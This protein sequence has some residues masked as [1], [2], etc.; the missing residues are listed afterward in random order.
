MG[1]LG[2]RTDDPLAGRRHPSAMRWVR[3]ELSSSFRSLLPGRQATCPHHDCRHQFTA[4]VGQRAQWKCVLVQRSCRTDGRRHVHLDRPTAGEEVQASDRNA[5]TA[6]PALCEEIP[7]GLETRVLRRAGI[8][9]WEQ[10]YS[11]ASVTCARRRIEADRTDA[12]VS[13]GA[14]P[15]APV[16]GRLRRDGRP[17]QP[18]GSLLSEGFRGN[19]QPS[20]RNYG[21]LLRDQPAC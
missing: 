19:G 1:L 13:S 12:H 4:F 17:R 15:A 21:L 14:R 10:L 11:P 5:L 20:F 6:P 16:A 18:L 2:L 7:H 8:L 3:Q 9:R